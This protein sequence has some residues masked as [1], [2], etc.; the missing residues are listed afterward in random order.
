MPS[1]M[2]KTFRVSRPT[3]LSLAL[4]GALSTTGCSSV[5]NLLGGDKV[6]YRTSGTQTVDL[7]VPPD[8]TQLSGQS[9]YNLQE[10]GAAVSAS[11][12]G[13]PAQP[14]GNAAPT[15]V[16]TTQTEQITLERDGQT[17]WLSTALPTE[18]VWAQ[19]QAF[20]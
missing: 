10:P 2:S 9:R 17:R 16:A 7:A 15:L 12:M 18:Q 4:V 1:H 8:L 19:A 11:E 20:W 6:D 14:A 13:S 3:A 5:N